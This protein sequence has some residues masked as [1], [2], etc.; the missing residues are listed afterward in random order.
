MA[1]T[2]STRTIT[3]HAVRNGREYISYSDNTSWTRKI[4]RAT[5]Q[6]ISDW[7]A[8]E[9]LPSS[10]SSEQ[11][12]LRHRRTPSRE[13]AQALVPLRPRPQR[14]GHRAGTGD[15]EFMHFEHAGSVDR[16][17]GPDFAWH[18]VLSGDLG[19][20]QLARVEAIVRA[21]RPPSAVNQSGGRDGVSSGVDGEG[22]EAVGGGEDCY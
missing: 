22:C 16:M 5:S 20:E 12:P 13:R 10:S 9:T 15:A 3:N 14:H 7:T 4:D 21:E 1:D 8:V 17:G 6:P 18:Q 19:D 11:P 2:E